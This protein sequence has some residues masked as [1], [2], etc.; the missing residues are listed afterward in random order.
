MKK[1]YMIL[2]YGLTYLPAAIESIYDQ[3]DQIFIAYTPKPSQGHSTEMNCPDSS[4]E[5]LGSI[6]KWADK[7][8][9]EVGSWNNEGEHTEAGR[10][11]ANLKDDD[12]LIRLDSDEIFQPGAVDFFIGMAKDR[13]EHQFGLP[14]IHFWKS[15]NKVCRD[16]QRPIR[17]ERKGGFGSTNL[18]D[19]V[20]EK[21]AIL[22]FGYA[23]PDKYIRY[24]MEVQGHRDEWREDW[25]EEKWLKNAQTDVH[26]VSLKFWNTEDYDLNKL[27][28][29]VIE[30]YLAGENEQKR[31]Q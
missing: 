25:Y 14:F 26:P 29:F 16:G 28:S 18:P 30:A 1:A 17:L 24:K 8:T 4:D 19:T 6:Q 27:P 31:I 11:M 10:K 9:V 2:H 13:N 23:Q 22:H 7:I 12:W 21:Y 5:L 3:V 15:L 20:D